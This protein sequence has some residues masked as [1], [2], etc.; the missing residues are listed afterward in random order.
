MSNQDHTY[1]HRTDSVIDHMP[2]PNSLTQHLW[3]KADGFALADAPADWLTKRTADTLTRWINAYQINPGDD[4]HWDGDVWQV[5]NVS[6]GAH[7]T[8]V[9]LAKLGAKHSRAM[10]EM[11][12]SN[13]VKVELYQIWWPQ[14]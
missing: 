4:I 3:A 2:V 6:H 14:R 9:H 10:V 7:Q 12:A 11:S 5:V 13:P 1:I 8:N